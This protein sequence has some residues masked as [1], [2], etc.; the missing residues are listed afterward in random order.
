M[1]GKRVLYLKTNTIDNSSYSFIFK[2]FF[3][4]VCSLATHLL[5]MNNIKH[6]IPLQV[7]G[8]KVKLF[9]IVNMF[10]HTLKPI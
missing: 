5:L 3:F 1:F 10:V 4:P 9:L 8:N 6:F 2:M 7:L